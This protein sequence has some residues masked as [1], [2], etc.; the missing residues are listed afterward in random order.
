MKKRVLA[1]ALGLLRAAGF[2]TSAQA[3]QTVTFLCAAPAGHVCQFAV[4]TTRGP[5]SSSACPRSRRMR[6]PWRIMAQEKGG[7]L[8]LENGWVV[9]LRTGVYGTDYVQRAFVTAV[10]LAANDPR[11]AVYP[12]EL[13]D[14]QGAK[15][16]GKNSYVIR[17]APRAFPPARG[18][19]S[20]TMYNDKWFFVANPLNRYTLSQ[21]NASKRNADGSMDLYLQA[22]NP[23]KDRESNWLPAPQGE[24]ILMFRLY[25]PE[26][27]PAFFDS[28]WHLEA[29]GGAEGLRYDRLKGPAARPH[30][31]PLAKS[32]VSKDDPDRRLVRASGSVLR[33]RACGV[34]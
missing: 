11:D 4:Q 23:A 29:A 19:W 6:P 5:R 25:M 7:G 27:A 2:M 10:G 13:N 30:P 26:E 34:P 17:F 33:G 18:F 16:D 32:S 31:E 8:T 12:F 15:L 21:R 20:L 9:M 3:Q 22:D 1:S 14:A 24:F 28:G